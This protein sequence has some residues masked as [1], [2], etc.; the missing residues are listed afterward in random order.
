MIRHHN[1]AQLV[2]VGCGYSTC[3]TL[4]VCDGLKLDTKLT[5]IDP[6]PE[7]MQRVVKPSDFSRFTFREECIQDTPMDLFTG[8]AA[9]D[10]LFID[11]SH[12]SKTGSDVNHIFFEILP[13]LQPGVIV[14]FH[15]IWYP[16]EYPMDWLHKGMFW[17]EAFLLRSF[18]MFNTSFEILMFN[19]Y[20]SHRF[21]DT[22]RTELPRFTED[23]PGTSLW[24][25]R[26]SEP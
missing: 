14:H 17:N 15:D 1:P 10:I 26:K 4:D 24:I 16:F 9:N 18:L 25:R 11:T 8:L 2:E 5:M 3:V 23:H 22:I 12:V 20:A 21:A 13:R 6:Y 19:D 7:W